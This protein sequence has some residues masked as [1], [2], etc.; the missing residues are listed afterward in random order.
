M[1]EYSSLVCLLQNIL[2][3]CCYFTW[4]LIACDVWLTCKGICER[5]KALRPADGSERR[6]SAGQ[7]RCAMWELFIK[8]ERG[9]MVY[10]CCGSK[11]R[12][13]P[14][15]QQTQEEE[16]GLQCICLTLE[17]WESSLDL[18][19]TMAA[20]CSICEIEFYYLDSQLCRM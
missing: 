11:L 3:F 12:V 16:E 14:R 17:K 6:Y 20:S 13:N 9:T 15:T 4:L 10:P 8:W 19:E 18:T 2:L 5:H 1:E 7:K